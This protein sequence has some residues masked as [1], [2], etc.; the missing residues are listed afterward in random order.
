MTETSAR[1]HDGTVVSVLGDVLTTTCTEG[2][3]HSY[4]MAKDAKVTCDGQA[5]KAADLKAGT[6]VRVTT[7]KDDKTVATAIE[8]GKHIPAMSHKESE[9]TLRCRVVAYNFSPKGAVDGL[10]V[11]AGGQP[12]QIVFPYDKGTELARCIVLGETVDLVVIER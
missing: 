8:F 10:L 6:H 3:Q 7:C 5:S 1:M 9:G 12:T 11:E 2:K 4:T